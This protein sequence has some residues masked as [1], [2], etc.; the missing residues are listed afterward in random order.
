MGKR[1]IRSVIVSGD[2]E[3]Y[4]EIQKM[5]E[6]EGYSFAVYRDWSNVIEEKIK[7]QLKKFPRSKAT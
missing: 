2:K 4:E 1:A 6:E 5:K 3:V 7:P